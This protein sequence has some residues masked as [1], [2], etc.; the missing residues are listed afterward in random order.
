M[1][2]TIIT[3]I[4]P[5]SQGLKPRAIKGFR[6]SLK[7][8]ALWGLI[9]ALVFT[10]TA[11]AV[12]YR[13]TPCSQNYY[14]TGGVSH[15]CPSETPVTFGTGAK[16]A[17]ECMTCADRDGE[18]YPFYDEISGDCMACWQ[19]PATT[20]PYWNGTTCTACPDGKTWDSENL[21]CKESGPACA[22]TVPHNGGELCLVESAPFQSYSA[23]APQSP[24]E[25]DDNF[26]AT[27]GITT[28]AEEAFCPDYWA[29]AIKYCKDKGLN[30]P[31]M[32]ELLSIRK[33]IYGREDFN[34]AYYYYEN[35]SIANQSLYN[36]V[37][38]GTSSTTPEA[39]LI[40]IWS[41]TEYAEYPAG[42]AYFTH[43]GNTD[44]GGVDAQRNTNPD[45]EEWANE[46]RALCIK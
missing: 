17:S 3:T 15:E 35:L 42:A 30:I 23:L 9:F 12:A 34:D 37:T 6:G 26:L 19:V 16:S 39:D 5:H 1:A 10:S 21:I 33:A 8:K 14:C 41:C 24:D 7:T 11:L 18:S 25:E 4:A 22:F 32:E 13:C 20:T 36:F 40:E 46:F 2:K 29:G 43:F 44:T 27:Y 28:A 45:E 31:T 38:T